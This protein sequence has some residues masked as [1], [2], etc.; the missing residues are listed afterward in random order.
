MVLDLKRM[1]RIIEVNEK[2]TTRSSNLA[3]AI[4]ISIATFRI[5][6]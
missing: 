1:D 5:K 4:S 6:G 2:I 3:S